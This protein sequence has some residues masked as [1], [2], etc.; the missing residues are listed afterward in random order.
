M[1]CNACI[2]NKN[3]NINEL[4]C[5]QNDKFDEN[6]QNY[7][8]QNDTNFINNT[9]T[10]KYKNFDSYDNDNININGYSSS[11][12]NFSYFQKIIMSLDLKHTDTNISKARV[13]NSGYYNEK[14]LEP[15]ENCNILDDKSNLKT[16]QLI[17]IDSKI[18]K[19]GSFIKIS[20]KYDN[21]YFCFGYEKSE[22]ASNNFYN[23]LYEKGMKKNHFMITFKGGD[24]FIR[25]INN[26]YLFFK[27][28]N[29]QHLKKKNVINFGNTFI[30]I[31]V[32]L[33]DKNGNS[34][35]T[36]FL[37]HIEK[38]NTKNETECNINS[39]SDIEIRI[40][41]DQIKMKYIHLILLIIPL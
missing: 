31:T 10:N 27:I 33:K 23:F 30:I 29:Y 26:S 20:T 18:Q 21:D 9:V 28:I 1:G 17:I 22:E 25:N 37:N 36:E 8:V 7:G 32:D 11:N 12:Q 4:R 5:I 6:N 24:F 39:Y 13:L 16:L 3:V 35:N 19:K 40:V 41:V 14:I 2:Q 38:N 15:C 34:A